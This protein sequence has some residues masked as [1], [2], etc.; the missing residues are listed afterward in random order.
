MYI[1]NRLVKSGLSVALSTDVHDAQFYYHVL[2]LKCIF[3]ACYTSILNTKQ[4]PRESELKEFV[5]FFP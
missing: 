1:P 4:H 5:F 3:M 2:K